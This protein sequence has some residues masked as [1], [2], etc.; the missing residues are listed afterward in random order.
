MT[1]SPE[2]RDELLLVTEML[3]AHMLAL[4]VNGRPPP[5]TRD[6]LVQAQQVGAKAA[7][8]VSQQAAPMRAR[9]TSK[10]VQDASFPRIVC[11][12]GYAEKGQ[13]AI[14]VLCEESRAGR[15]VLVSTAG[16][17]SDLKLRRI[18]LAD[19]VLVMNAWGTSAFAAQQQEALSYVAYARAH[20]KR[21]RFTDEVAGAAWLEG[22][23]EKLEEL[24]G[25]FA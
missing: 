18:D 2:T 25:R 12:G 5:T 19:E 9:R 21:V 14:D 6:I 17:D 24:V 10:Y 7:A 1:L 3:G 8:E 11:L 4:A 22:N 23:R 15:L 13:D 20:G 16:E